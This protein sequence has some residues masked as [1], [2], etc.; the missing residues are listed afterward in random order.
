MVSSRSQTTAQQYLAVCYCFEINPLF[1]IQYPRYLHN[2][3]EPSFKLSCHAYI[4][5]T[6][7]LTRFTVPHP[8]YTH[9]AL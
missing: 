1:I 4:M 9:T 7:Q 8:K 2:H 6:A 3:S 5:P